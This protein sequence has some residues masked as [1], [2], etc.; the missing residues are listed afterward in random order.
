M[1]LS[2]EIGATIQ[3][4]PVLLRIVRTL[5]PLVGS[6]ARVVMTP[7][8]EFTAVVL[9]ITPGNIAH[10]IF[11]RHGFHLLMKHYYLPIPEEG[12]LGGQFWERQ[13]ELVG[14]EINDDD[15][16]HIMD[17]VL[18]PY[19]QEFRLSFPVH[20]SS[21]RADFFLING[22]FMAIDAHVYYSFIRH[23]KPRRIVEIGS[24][25]STL[26]ASAA[27]VRNLAETGE[28]PHFV[29]IEPFP[30]SLLKQGIR[31]LTQLIQD[32]VQ[33]VDVEVFSSLGS[34]DILFIDSSHV[35]RSGGDVQ[36][37]YCEILPRL[38]PGV[39]V[40]VH[41]ISLPRPYPRVYFDNELYWN[42]QYLLQ[43]LLS[44]TSR[45]E[46]VWP[47]NHMMLKYPERMTAVFPEYHEMR[48]LF[49]QAEPSS[50]WIRVRS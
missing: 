26:L 19:L 11:Y 18:P 34:G 16:L 14:I 4:H 49:P 32:K 13:S 17:E 7:L 25:A 48:K 24:G 40:H 1:S 38:A 43:V 50:F 10:G 41:D 23:F 3:K 21:Q 46:V 31:G 36:L 44:F 30:S 5:R 22:T 35:L 47:G 12:D 2:A 15:A 45:Y 20:E 29:A 37:E 42:E 39:L 28:S 8:L 9:S 6:V 33:K 27:C